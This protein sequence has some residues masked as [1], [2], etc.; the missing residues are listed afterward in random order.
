ML[1][2]LQGP[3]GRFLAERH[4]TSQLWIAGG[5]GITPF[6]ATL[7]RE[8]LAHP[9]TLIYLYRSAQDAAY[10]EELGALAA[11]DPLLTLTTSIADGLP[12]IDSLLGNVAELAKREV[13]LCGPAPLVNAAREAL[14]RHGVP[15]SSI[16]FER[17]DFR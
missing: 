17:F 1:V 2:R 13:Q 4:A 12:D 5:I 10:L 3:F 6:L 15:A 14:A 8:R 9:T 7:R 11:A 16:H